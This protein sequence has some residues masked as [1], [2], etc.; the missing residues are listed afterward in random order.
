MPYA[1]VTGGGKGIGRAIA[2]A[3]AHAGYDVILHANRSREGMNQV[4]LEVQKLGRRTEEMVADLS[5]A[6]GLNDLIAFVKSKTSVLDVLVHNAGLFE[7]VPFDQVTKAQY[8]AMQAL[9]M[10]VPFWLTQGLLVLL[11]GSKK[12]NVV[13]ITD[14]FVKRPFAFYTHYFASKAAMEGLLRAL[15]AELS[16]AIRVNGVAPG[17][18]SPPSDGNAQS[19]MQS[20]ENRIPLKRLGKEAEVAQAVIYLVKEATY[21]TGH[22]MDVDGGRTLCT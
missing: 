1:L 21:T 6:N 8:Q 7:R 14:A 15:A 10:D 2:L 17:L 18:I 11:K 13:F 20:L 9:H 19:Q 3:L 4:A 22:I 12:A 16:P 5:N